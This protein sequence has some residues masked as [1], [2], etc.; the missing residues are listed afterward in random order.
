M[1]VGGKPADARHPFG[2]SKA[3]YFSAVIEGVLIVVAA[4][5][6][7]HEA[8]AAYFN[9]RLIDAPIEGMAVNSPATVVNS[10]WAAFLIVMGIRCRSPPLVAALRHLLTDVS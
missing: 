6:I 1:W 8:Y 3:E 10:P 7:L 2:H 9:P 5:V 4:L